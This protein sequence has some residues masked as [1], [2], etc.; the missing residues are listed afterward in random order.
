MK[1][2]SH[3]H[4]GARQ[5][6]G[7]ESNNPVTDWLIDYDI[8]DEGFAEDPYSIFEDLRKRCTFATT[9]RWSGSIMPVHFDSI[10]EVA[11][12]HERFSSHEVNVIPRATTTSMLLP[13]GLQPIELDP[14]L[15]AEVRR[16]IQSWFAPAHVDSLE[17]FTRA[18]CR[19][20]IASFQTL[21]TVDAAEA[22][23]RQIPLRVTS[24]MLG[25]PHEAADAFSDAVGNRAPGDP[26]R[27]KALRDMY[28]RFVE[29]ISR[30]EATPSSD[31]ISE[32][33]RSTID[34]RPLD[35]DD[36]MGMIVL[37]LS[38][39]VDTTWSSI[40]AS[41]WHLATHPSDRVRLLEDPALMPGAVEEFL[42]AYSPVTMARIA[43]RDTDIGGCPVSAGTRVV[44]SFPAANR[45]PAAFSDP[46]RVDL[47][48]TNNRHL[49]FGAGIHRCAGANLARME[50]RVALEE[51]LGSIPDFAVDPSSRVMWSTGQVRGPRS[52]R[53][54]FPTGNS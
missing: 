17:T 4:Y 43:T 8:Y 29:E 23:A 12:D 34:G 50:I 16:L 2:P 14:P 22:Y 24:R 25:I 40:G 9:E 10:S 51:W 42:R 48:R 41:L 52:L 44:L 32:V 49:A 21:G 15:H 37:M 27:G 18:T 38:A 5:G 53:L 26:R 33:L 46:D 54:V 28:D 7:V 30:R 39:G 3:P 20:L 13:R 11:R 35:R 45:D 1:R 36:A 47:E 31:I 6:Y 19:E